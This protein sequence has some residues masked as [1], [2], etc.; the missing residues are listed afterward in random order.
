[1]E[2]V[3]CICTV[4][5][6]SPDWF[7]QLVWLPTCTQERLR[8]QLLDVAALPL[9]CRVPGGFLESLWSSDVSRGWR[10]QQEGLAGRTAFLLG[11]L[12]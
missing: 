5:V 4:K 1:M 9:W 10:Q 8:T 7:T 3:E 2:L 6:D 12:I 11:P